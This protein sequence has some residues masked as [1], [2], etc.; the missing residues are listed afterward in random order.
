MSY[1]LIIKKGTVVLESEAVITD[2]AV[3]N[4]KIVAIGDDLTGAEKILS[5]EGLI[6]APGMVDAHTHISEPGRSHWEGYATGTRAA[7]KGGITTMI[8]MPLNQLPATVDRASLHM[9]FDA[10]EGKLT[11]TKLNIDQNP[12][13]APKYGIRGIPTLLL[14][15]N[16]EVAATKVGALSKGQLK[17]FLNANL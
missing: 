8:E 2:I 17:D 3:K 10:A 1:D 5:A 4:G 9:K 14:F 11:I 12:A 15:K 6:V 16:G 7:A 13:T